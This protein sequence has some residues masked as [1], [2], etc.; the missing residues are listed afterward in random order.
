MD[1]STPISITQL[2]QA[3]NYWRSRSP[4]TGEEARLG[5]E[6][7]ALATPYALL[8][9]TGARELRAASLDEAGRQA[10]AAWLDAVQPGPPAAATNPTTNPATNSAINPAIKPTKA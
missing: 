8:I 7:A 6:A 2:E 10:Y 3:I 1:D 5:R 9:Y 4:S